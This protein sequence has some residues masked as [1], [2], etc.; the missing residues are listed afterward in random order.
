M[1]I[2][3]SLPLVDNVWDKLLIRLDSFRH[4]KKKK[5][6]NNQGSKCYPK[7]FLSSVVKYYNS[8]VLVRTPVV[9]FRILDFW[10]ISIVKSSLV[11][12]IESNDF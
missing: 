5:N 8:T 3:D 6:Y 10:V 11:S 9:E 12:L 7:V 1:D 2:F 4:Q